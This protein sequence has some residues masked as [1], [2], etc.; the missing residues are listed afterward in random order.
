MIGS[1]CRWG[2]SMGRKEKKKTTWI[3]TF[4]P[5]SSRFLDAVPLAIIYF[6]TGE[7]TI[8]TPF[9]ELHL[10]K[11]DLWYLQDSS[12]WS[13]TLEL[14][15]L[16]KLKIVSRE[17]KVEFAHVCISVTNLLQIRCVK[18]CCRNACDMDALCLCFCCHVLVSCI[19]TVYIWY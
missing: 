12:N 9:P 18:V 8:W 3:C 19:F 5:P 16:N 15:C 6:F 11:K 7:W 13:L 17:G 14:R 4:R 10:I 2:W 1:S